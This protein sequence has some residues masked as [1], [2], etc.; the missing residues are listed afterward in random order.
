MFYAGHNSI[1]V[2]H[3]GALVTMYHCFCYLRSVPGVLAGTFRYPAPPRIARYINHGRKN[4]VY[5]FGGS[6]LSRNTRR[7]LNKV[8][9]PGGSHT[10]RYREDGTVAVDHV[11]AKYQRN[12]Q[13]RVFYRYFLCFADIIG[14][15]YTKYPAD[16]TFFDIG[17]NAFINN[18][19][20]DRLPAAGYQ[21]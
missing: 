15:P 16:I 8:H 21:V 4:P 3:I 20:G 11:E 17:F 9:V 18:G 6:F 10:Q 13:A 12:V 14:S 5:A 7:L 19:T 1:C 2:F